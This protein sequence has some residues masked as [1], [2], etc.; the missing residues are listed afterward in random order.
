MALAGC[1]TIWGLT[2]GPAL[3]AVHSAV[4]QL[5]FLKPF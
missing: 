1:L 5:P 2:P 3:G 4:S